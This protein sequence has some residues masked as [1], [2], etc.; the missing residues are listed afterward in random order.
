MLYIDD[1]LGV[2]HT[3][4]LCEQNARCVKGSLEEAGWVINEKKSRWDPSKRTWLGLEIDTAAYTLRITDKRIY[5]ILGALGEL[6]TQN[7][8][9]PPANGN[10][11]REHNF[12]ASRFR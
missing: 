3:Q 10:C 11:C 9:S 5:K 6:I 4:E 12:H 2:A 1:G 8:C 7:S